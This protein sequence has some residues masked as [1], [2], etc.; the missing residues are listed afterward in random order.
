VKFGKEWGM[1]QAQIT[2]E[3]NDLK[4]LT[5]EYTNYCVNWFNTGLQRMDPTTNPSRK[6]ANMWDCT[7]YPWITFDQYVSWKGPTQN[8]PKNC[9]STFLNSICD[10][11]GIENDSEVTPQ[12][13]PYRASKNEY[14]GLEN[15]NLY[16]NFRRDMTIMVLDIVSSWPTY[17]PIQ[18]PIG[19]IQ[20]ELT[21]ALYTPIRGTTYRSDP[22]QNTI[23]AIENRMI[24]KPN[25]FT[26]LNR[27]E[28]NELWVSRSSLYTKGYL[29][30]GGKILRNRTL[31]STLEELFGQS[32]SGAR[33]I[34]VDITPNDP[35]TKI[36]T[37]QWFEPREIEIYKGAT[38]LFTLGTIEEPIPNFTGIITSGCYPQGGV[39]KPCI[40]DPTWKENMM[41]KAVNPNNPSAPRS[42]WKDS[43]RLSYFKYE[44]IR[45]DSPYG[46]PSN[47]QIGAVALEW[48]HMSVD[49]NNTIAVDKITR[50]PAVKAYENSGTVIKGPGFTGGDLIQLSFRNQVKLKITIP[51]NT[52]SNIV[53]YE[54]RFRYSSNHPTRIGVIFGT[55]DY[56]KSA[57]YDLAATHTNPNDALKYDSF[58]ITTNNPVIINSQLVEQRG[59]LLVYN[60]RNPSSIIIDKIEFIPIE[61]SLEEY[62]ANQTLEKAR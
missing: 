60:V 11:Q 27:I 54:L 58:K 8:P 59:T 34:N 38:Y 21:R 51:A 24:Q 12:I 39:P 40:Y 50:I 4:R 41:S 2:T 53:G 7:T 22:A 23:S 25:L 3:Y 62:E 31:G 5:T 37:R 46:Y 49:P 13:G 42:Q 26:W 9:K 36:I 6:P 10:N 52:N 57:P 28:F 15:W 48:T 44:P 30:I 29:L 18:Y 32:D 17:D 20:S 35:I 56:E 45:S 16:N 19:G 14:Q 47:G 43:H 1:T 33:K 55:K 61:G